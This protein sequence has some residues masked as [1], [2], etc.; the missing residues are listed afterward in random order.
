M[1]KVSIIVPVHNA[2]DT[3]TVCVESI[4]A[5]TYS[6][7]EVILV[8]NHSTDDSYRL[9]QEL[10]KK[11]QRIKVIRSEKKGV[12]AARNA[13]IQQAGGA[14]IGFCDADDYM[15][16]EMYAYLVSLL[17][18]K[19][20]SIAMCNGYVSYEKK[21][22][23][24]AMY[25]ED[26]I[27]LDR[28]EAILT[29]HKRSFLNAYVWNKLFIR[30]LLTDI[31]FD[32]K[33]DF[34]EDYDFIC[35]ALEKTDRMVCGS[36]QMYHYVQKKY[37]RDSKKSIEPYRNAQKM[38]EQYYNRW[39]T[40]FPK[41]KSLFTCYYMYDIL[42]LLAAVSKN[43]KQSY[44]DQKE[45]QQIVRTYKRAYMQSKEAPLVMKI[46]ALSASV[47]ICLYAWEYRFVCFLRNR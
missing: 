22:K 33:L 27:C 4:L 17:E 1:K 40:V 34:A 24:L 9:C 19:E 29:L 46:C 26:V 25:P 43:G 20:A 38:F 30:E 8:E 10:Q 5:Q 36:K 23:A 28:K 44:S 11:D 14:Y 32:E 3:L 37:V 47:S 15:E 13:G 16:K 41:E 21:E 45:L 12:S 6:D 7:L 39:M 42:G 35:K 18:E 31:F 2:A